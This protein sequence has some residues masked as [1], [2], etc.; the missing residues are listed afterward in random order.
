MQT[1]QWPDFA[2]GQ[3]Y[4]IPDVRDTDNACSQFSGGLR[5]RS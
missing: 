4:T 3:S 2:S 5:S 1:R